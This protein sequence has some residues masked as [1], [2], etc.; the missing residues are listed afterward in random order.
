MFGRKQHIEALEAEIAQ[1]RGVQQEVDALRPW[2]GLARTIKEETARYA[3]TTDVDTAVNLAVQG[4]SEE[5]RQNFVLAAFNQLNPER[6][7]EMLAT[8]FG[9]GIIKEALESE[10]QKRLAQLETTNQLQ[11]ILN[12]A[13]EHKRI[14][15]ADIPTD[16]KVEMYLYPNGKLD[17]RRRVNSEVGDWARHIRGIMQNTGKLA[18]LHDTL[19][20]RYFAPIDI[21]NATYD[22]HQKMLPVVKNHPDSPLY[23]GAEA[24]IPSAVPGST[25]MSMVADLGPVIIND[26][27]IFDILAKDT[28]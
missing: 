1:L 15:F 6:Q 8:T 21:E 25:K 16:A 11:A 7:L 20:P 2:I 10:R 9:D 18:I 4:A 24:F 14:R 27:D 23:Y 5:Q 12:E 17:G 26:I 28:N 3:A 19:N 13:R 22:D